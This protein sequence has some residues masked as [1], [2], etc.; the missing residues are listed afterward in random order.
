MSKSHTVCAVMEA[1]EK[2]SVSDET[3]Q[4]CERAIDRARQAEGEGFRQE[5]LAAVLK[6][7]EEKALPASPS[8]SI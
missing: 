2:A 8:P 7:L 4:A 6:E 1:L 5:M 3:Y